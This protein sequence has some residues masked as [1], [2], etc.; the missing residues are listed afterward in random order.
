MENINFIL[1][2]AAIGI[3]IVF[4]A[5][6]FIAVTITWIRRADE[7]WQA[8]EKKQDE[9]A[10]GKAQTLDTTTLVIISAVCATILG[11]KFHIRRVRRLQPKETGVGPWAHQGRSVLLGSHVVSK[12]RR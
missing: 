8:K 10:F 12:N 9:D 3:S 1:K 5:L 7:G 2:F 4:I 11:G 6:A